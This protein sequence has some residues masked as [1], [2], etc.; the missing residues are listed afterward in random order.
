APAA[1]MNCSLSS[2][3]AGTRTLTAS[4][5]PDSATF[6]ASSS[7]ASHLVT[8]ATTTISVTAPARSRINQPTAFSFE[9]AATAPGAGMPTGSVTL[10]SGSSSCT[11]TLPATSCDLSFD[12]LGSRTVSASYAG[13][14]NYLASDS[15][16]AGSLQT[17][18]YALADVSISKTD[19]LATYAPNDLIVYTVQ[20]RNAG[21]DDAAQIRVQDILP[22]SLLSVIWFADPAS[23]TGDLDLVLATLP[24]G[25]MED[26]TIYGRV[27]GSPEQVVN[28]ATLT[29]PADTTVE[30]PNPGNNSATDVNL[31]EGLFEDGFESPAV[32]GPAGS[33]RLPTAALAPLLD[34]VA[35]VVYRL[36]D[37]H[38]DVAR[39]YA[40]L[41]GEA[42]EYALAKRGPDGRWT[43]GAWQSYA[44]EPTL[45]WHAVLVGDRWQ[46]TEV[47]LH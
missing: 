38:G 5:L 2:S 9:L 34:S 24:A 19:G 14:A 8:A 42:V 12:T 27:N 47:E 39:I 17:L 45:A 18:V 21:P 22:T 4:Y 37:D 29:L 6:D 23:G 16:A 26:F 10:T 46:L 13:D 35:R 25:A 41:D 1:T 11:A 28:T 7:T 40:R 33:L 44:Q 20:V 32:T 36:D 3:T 30:D 15:G 31:L 43:L